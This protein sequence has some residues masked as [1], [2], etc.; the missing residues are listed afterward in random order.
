MDFR[1]KFVAACF[2]ATMMIVSNADLEIM[3]G[4]GGI[5]V[6]LGCMLVFAFIA[7]WPSLTRGDMADRTAPGGAWSDHIEFDAPDGKIGRDT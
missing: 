2:F 6:T 3:H 5:F 4:F 7:L 1:F